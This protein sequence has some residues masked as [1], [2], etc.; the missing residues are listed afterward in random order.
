MIKAAT[1]RFKINHSYYE[2]EP[3]YKSVLSMRTTSFF[4][5]IFELRDTLTSYASRDPLI[6]IVHQRIVNEGSTHFKE[7]LYIQWNEYPAS[8]VRIIREKNNR[9]NIDSIIYSNNPGYDM[10]NLFLFVRTLDYDS[11]SYGDT[12]RLTNFVGRKKVEI[13]VRHRGQQIVEKNKNLKYKTIKF[14]VDIVDEV[15][16]ESKNAM[17]IWI[18]DDENRLPIKLKAKLKIGAAEA[19]ITSARNLKHPFTAEINLKK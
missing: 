14:D 15:F 12:F 5:G 1:A 19:L 2:G 10:L 8:Q 18:S 7:N 4:D 16:S 17:E 9:I 3:A 13:L 6:P 11:I